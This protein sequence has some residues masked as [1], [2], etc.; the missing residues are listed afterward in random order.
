[1]DNKTKQ[2]QGLAL[3]LKIAVLIGEQLLY[4]G[5]FK[6]IQAALKQS[7]DPGQA[8]GQFLFQM[9][10][11][12]MENMPDH[13][14]LSPAILLA[15]DGWLVQISDF[16]QAKLG[17]PKAVMDKAEI[18]VASTATKMAQAKQQQGG[19]AINGIQ[20]PPVGTPGNVAPQGQPVMPQQAGGGQ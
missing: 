17:V 1:M 5:G 13:V 15:K 4:Q 18:Y 9:G 2:P 10:Q 8:I 12:M 16:I 3:D 14:K 20:A 11:Q 19:G 6:A 7:S